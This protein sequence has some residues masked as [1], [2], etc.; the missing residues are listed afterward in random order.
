MITI[1]E[2]INGFD[3]C[4]E[5]MSENEFAYMWIF[6]INTDNSIVFYKLAIAG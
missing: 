5:Y 4:T 2:I 1:S 6:R 3:E